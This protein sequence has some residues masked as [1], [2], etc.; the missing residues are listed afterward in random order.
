MIFKGLKRT[1]S[2]G[3]EPVSLETAKAHCRVSGTVE[4]DLIEGYLKAAREYCETY[5][6]RSFIQNEWVGTIN[7]FP[8]G[9]MVL[10]MGPVREV[11]K[12][13]Y[14]QEYGGDYVELTDFVVDT[15]SR[16]AFVSP[17]LSG[18]PKAID[19]A[20]SV[21]VE[22]KTG[23]EDVVADNPSQLIPALLLLTE[24]YFNNRSALQAG[25][26]VEVPFGVT[27]ICDQLKIGW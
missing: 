1:S 9:D 7:C 12:I 18:W 26:A 19:A 5:C 17:P 22:F 16:M 15:Y 10:P 20:A 6:N 25:S 27:A 2:G 23:P 3:V 24:H 21:K 13:S 8:D 4:D 11:T 14:R